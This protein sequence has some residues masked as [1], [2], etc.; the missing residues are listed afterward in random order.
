MVDLPEN[1][2]KGL[3]CRLIGIKDQIVKLGGVRVVVFYFGRYDYFYGMKGSMFAIWGCLYGIM[4][5][6]ILDMDTL[7]DLMSRFEFTSRGIELVEHFPNVL[8]IYK[9][10]L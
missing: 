5:Y 6:G 3:K 9:F 8:I 7:I 4:R 1:R 2:D 10:N